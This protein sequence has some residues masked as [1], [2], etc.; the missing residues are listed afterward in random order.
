[1]YLENFVPI[2]GEVVRLAKINEVSVPAVQTDIKKSFGLQIPQNGIKAILRRLQKRGYIKSKNQIYTRDLDALSKLNFHETQ[3]QV[4]R[5]HESLITHL[6]KF[7]E[8]R[9]GISFT[10][11]EAE[12]AFQEYIQ[13]NQL[14]ITN[15]SE[16]GN[17]VVPDPDL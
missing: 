10:Q 14:S 3:Q 2:V 8:E 5:M 4:L 1:D 17:T 6:Q 13:D 9:F 11:E 16:D 12:N 15:F 7:S